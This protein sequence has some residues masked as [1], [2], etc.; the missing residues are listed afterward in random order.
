MI[1]V[2][3]HTPRFYQFN[4]RYI[5]GDSININ[6]THL[7]K[8]NEMVS[9]RYEKEILALDQVHQPIFFHDAFFSFC[10][11]NQYQKSGRVGTELILIDRSNYPNFTQND[12]FFFENIFKEIM[13]EFDTFLKLDVS[14]H[15][16]KADTVYFKHLD[17][18]KERIERRYQKK[19]I[20]STSQPILNNIPKT[21]STQTLQHI[22]KI[23][24][25]KP[26][27]FMITRRVD[28][29]KQ[30]LSSSPPSHQLQQIIGEIEKEAYTLNERQWVCRDQYIFLKQTYR[31]SEQIIVDEVIC[32]VGLDE[33][34]LDA[35]IYSKLQRDIDH[36][37]QNELFQLYEKYKKQ[38]NFNQISE[39]KVWEEQLFKYI[40][41]FEKKTQKSNHHL[42]RKRLLIIAT[43]TLLLSSLLFIIFTKNADPETNN[44]QGSQASNPNTQASNPNTQA[45][46][47]NTQASNPNT[48]ASNPNTQASNPSLSI[49]PPNLPANINPSNL[50]NIQ[51]SNPSNNPSAN[52]PSANNPSTN[53]PS[54][55]NPTI[56]QSPI[57]DDI[58][59]ACRLDTENLKWK[60]LCWINENKGKLQEKFQPEWGPRQ[61]F[62]LPALIKNIDLSSFIKQDTSLNALQ[63]KVFSINQSAIDTL[64]QDC[65]WFHQITN[66][67]ALNFILNKNE[68]DILGELFYYFDQLTH[69]KCS[70]LKQYEI[71]LHSFKLGSKTFTPNE[72]VRL[73]RISQSKQQL[74]Q[75]YL[76]PSEKDQISIKI[77]QHHQEYCL[78]LHQTNQFKSCT[79]GQKQANDLITP[80]IFNQEIKVISENNKQIKLTF[81]LK[82]TKNDLQKL[83]N[84]QKQVYQNIEQL[85]Q[86]YKAKQISNYDYLISRINF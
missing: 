5:I 11:I 58:E 41:P 18:I 27:L 29:N 19:K 12:R 73:S 40:Q 45:S 69:I 20:I 77:N 21:T 82:Y 7:Y 71:E 38:K 32:Y 76:D 54:A 47:P 37:T 31:S 67:S 59:D 1:S 3:I 44:I 50:P 66:I 22:E 65:G 86:A 46:N 84:H 75:I 13:K 61:S 26:S 85:H 70:H 17:L 24:M 74:G 56:D 8:I 2:F 51:I 63:A 36:I 30:I 68:I 72:V 53:N 16:M 49:N 55:N 78:D 80:E 52:N 25:T 60:A 10:L 28:S 43:I 14:I 81:N 4:Y 83:N 33:Y 23:N 57:V 15:Q 34:H 39:I 79:D 42:T 9:T 6:M 35:D 62:P 64:N 48:Q